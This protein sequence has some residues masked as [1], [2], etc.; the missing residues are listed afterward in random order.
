MFPNRPEC[1]EN[2]LNRLQA[3][4]GGASPPQVVRLLFILVTSSLLV[5]F[6]SSEL[7]IALWY[8]VRLQV[9]H[10]TTIKNFKTCWNAS[11]SIWTICKHGQGIQSGTSLI[12]HCVREHTP[13]F[14][15]TSCCYRMKMF[16]QR[17]TLQDGRHLQTPSVGY[18][19]VSGVVIIGQLFDFENF[20]S[21]M[22]EVLRSKIRRWILFSR[23]SGRFFTWR[24]IPHDYRNISN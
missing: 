17:V 1:I 18:V 23:T 8:N 14:I 9:L 10:R 13:D 20:R 19:Y 3:C 21:H 12:L 4:P 6:L 5:S 24:T 11:K 15:E 7:S 22:V 16:L 2:R